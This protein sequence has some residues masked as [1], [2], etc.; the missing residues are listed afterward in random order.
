MPL[1]SSGLEDLSC[2]PDHSPWDCQSS[3]EAIQ[4]WEYHLAEES[5]GTMGHSV[6]YF[7][8]GRQT[9]RASVGRTPS[10]MIHRGNP[11]VHFRPGRVVQSILS[12]SAAAH[13]ALTHPRYF[14]TFL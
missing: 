8:E 11:N 3:T 6:H 10:P 2:W 14:Q 12:L 4:N 5:G 7:L 13:R 1:Q 9:A